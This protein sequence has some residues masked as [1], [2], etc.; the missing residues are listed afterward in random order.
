MRYLSI[1]PEDKQFMLEKIGAERIEDLFETIPEQVRL[2]KCFGSG[3]RPV[4]VRL[5]GEV[6]DRIHAMIA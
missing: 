6:D 3:Y 4:D 2:N 5:R 1:T